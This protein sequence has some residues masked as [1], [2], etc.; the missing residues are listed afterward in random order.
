MTHVIPQ[1]RLFSGITLRDS[2]RRAGGFVLTAKRRF[3]ESGGLTLRKP[4]FGVLTRGRRIRQAPSAHATSRPSVYRI[5]VQPQKRFATLRVM[6][7][8]VA[9]QR[10][11][12]I[13]LSVLLLAG[14]SAAEVHISSMQSANVLDGESPHLLVTGLRPGEQA[15]VH[16]SL[17]ESARS[18]LKWSA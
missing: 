11:A 7:I 3:G 12:L 6:T 15:T 9:A 13:C 16:A 10:I 8:S 18:Q 14:T 5:D 4:T 1:H 17:G 2:V